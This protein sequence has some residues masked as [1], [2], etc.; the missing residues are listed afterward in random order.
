MKAIMTF[1]IKAGFIAIWMITCFYICKGNDGF[2]M[3][4]YW[5]ICGFPFGITKMCMILMPKDFDIAG[6]VGVLALNVVIGGIVGG[7]ILAAKII[8]LPVE[9]VKNLR[10]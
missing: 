4:K 5:I 7:F 1:I 10:R 9:L 8:R 6:G 3:F 2:D